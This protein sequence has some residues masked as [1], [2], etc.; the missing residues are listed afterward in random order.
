MLN[1]IKM[2]RYF[3]PNCKRFKKRWQTTEGCG[4]SIDA[5]GYG[6][7]VTCRHCGHKIIGVTKKYVEKA[8]MDKLKAEG[9]E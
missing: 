1:K 3:C 4:A 6:P 7:D 8:V 5:P 9:E 2:T